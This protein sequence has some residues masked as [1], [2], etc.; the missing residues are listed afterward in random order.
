M[1]IEPRK[2]SS[3]CADRYVSNLDQNAVEDLH[4]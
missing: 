4:V 2:R 1:R 3:V